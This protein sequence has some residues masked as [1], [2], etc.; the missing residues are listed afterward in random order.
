MSLAPLDRSEWADKYGAPEETSCARCEVRTGEGYREANAAGLCSICALVAATTAEAEMGKRAEQEALVAR[1]MRDVARDIANLVD[2]GADGMEI[3]QRL[4][5][6]FWA[7]AECHGR[8][9]TRVALRER[10]R[11]EA[12]DVV[13]GASA[14]A[15]REP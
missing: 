15:R 13:R 1:C 7:E 11:A 2:S 9:M 5:E 6:D 14:A 12:N 10:E 3:A 4:L 8:R